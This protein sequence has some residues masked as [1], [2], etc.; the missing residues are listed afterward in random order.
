MLV[1]IPLVVRSFA[2]L[3]RSMGYNPPR[4]PAQTPI[5]SFGIP[6]R[7]IGRTPQRSPA[8][9]PIPRHPPFELGELRDEVLS[10]INCLPIAGR[11]KRCNEIT[12]WIRMKTFPIPVRGAAFS[13][14]CIVY[15]PSGYGILPDSLRVAARP[16]QRDAAPNLPCTGDSA[17][18]S[19]P[20]PFA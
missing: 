15:I 5:P 9:I 17:P 4:N 1:I 19:I 16:Y 2:T 14:V 20:L 18:P 12:L 13:D 3:I 7:S 10:G 11:G 8:R 6:P